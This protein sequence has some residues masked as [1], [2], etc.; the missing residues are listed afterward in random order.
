MRSYLL[1][2]QL[3][4]QYTEASFC[5][6]VYDEVMI[7]GYPNFITCLYSPLALIRWNSSHCYLIK[8]FMSKESVKEKVDSSNNWK[9][10]NMAE[11]DFR[12]TSISD[13]LPEIFQSREG[14]VQLG[15]FNKHFI[16]KLRKKAPQ[17][18]TLEF[19]LLDSLKTTF[20]MA[21]LT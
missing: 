8:L 15:H 13:A 6:Y 18:K 1:K 10:V 11:N 19:F 12:L 2:E 16:K 5:I 3:Q 4:I 7:E 17:G 21:N 9:T 14:F 20:W